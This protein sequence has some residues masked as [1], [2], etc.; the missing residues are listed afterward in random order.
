MSFDFDP[1][2]NHHF[3]DGLYAK[4]MWIPKGASIG[5]HIHTFSHL[6]VLAKGSVEVCAD[7]VWTVYVAPACIDITAHVEHEVHALEDAVW[8]CIHNSDKEV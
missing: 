6:S 7:G 8:Y 1:C 5:K 4:E 3:S 2:V